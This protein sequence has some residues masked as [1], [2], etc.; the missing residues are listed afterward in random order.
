MGLNLLQELTDETQGQLYI[1]LHALLKKTVEA[2][3]FNDA[4]ILTTALV[5]L[6]RPEN[7]EDYLKTQSVAT[8]VIPSPLN[9][10]PL[11]TPTPGGA[12]DNNQFFG[13]LEGRTIEFSS[14]GY[15]RR[16]EKELMRELLLKALSGVTGSKA[17][18]FITFAEIADI[19]GPYIRRACTPYFNYRTSSQSNRERWRELLSSVLAQL[20][21]E[22]VVEQ[23]ETNKRYR[24]TPVRLATQEESGPLLNI[25]Y[26]ANKGDS[27]VNCYDDELEAQK[28]LDKTIEHKRNTNGF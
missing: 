21:Q 10:L 3:E 24:L 5:T 8:T 15:Y 16:D 7:F 12:L 18:T 26:T 14:I 2:G 11:D 1:G 9:A 25:I 22:G 19:V 23:H 6:K 20:R 13:N 4:N 17:G 28:A 27:Q